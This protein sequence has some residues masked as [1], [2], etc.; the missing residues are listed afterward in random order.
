M[1]S[2]KP[3]PAPA[4]ISSTALKQASDA[5]E[6]ASKELD[7]SVPP[8]HVDPSQFNSVLHKGKDD[9]DT[10]CW[11]SPGGAG[12]MIRGQTYLKNSAKFILIL[13][14]IGV[15]QFHLPNLARLRPS[16][17]IM[18]GNP[19]LKLIAVD[20]FKVDKATDKIALHPKSLAQSDAGKNLPFI[21]VIN[22]ELKVVCLGQIDHALTF[23][24]TSSFHFSPKHSLV[25]Y[26]AAERP[27]R[28]DSLL[29]KFA[30]GT[31]QFRDARF[32]LIPSIVEGY[33]MVKR[34]VGTK[35][36]LL[37][38]AVT[39]KYFRQDNFLERDDYIH[40]F[41]AYFD[42][43]FTKCHKLMGFSTGPR[44]RATHW[45]QTVLY[46]EDVLTICEGETI[47][48]SM[49]VAPNKKNPRDVDIMVKYSLSGRRCV[50]SRVQFY[51][52]R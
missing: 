12:F 27:V 35:A 1:D 52:M 42:V 14:A 29:E 21:L 20:W 33:W 8:I 2:F 22:L 47:I 44:S 13:L 11:T 38:K 45:K 40:A 7:L 50:V 3:K 36:C 23:R 51:K 34:A 6:N 15:M 43:S 9:A 5:A 39:C 32:K 4:A 24:F 46:L 25:L 30:D 18:G 49:T 31:D 16:H 17:S 19:L 41:V 48:G 26:Y 10:N 37:G 28:K